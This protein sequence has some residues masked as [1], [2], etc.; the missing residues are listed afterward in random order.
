MTGEHGMTGGCGRCHGCG[1]DLIAV[2]D[3][4]EWCRKC[5][6]YRRY[7]SHGFGGDATTGPCP[8][9]PPLDAATRR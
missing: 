2:L 6:A 5:Q 4:E 7:R 1:K 9:E 3:G 8:E